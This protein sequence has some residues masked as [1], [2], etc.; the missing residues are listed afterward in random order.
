MTATAV[1]HTKRNT[2][3]VLYYTSTTAV[4]LASLKA[5]TSSSHG[6]ENEITKKYVRAATAEIRCTHRFSAWCAAADDDDD[7]SG[8]ATVTATSCSESGIEFQ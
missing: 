6:G 2:S 3:T 8:S 4:G 5:Q 7:E 1:A